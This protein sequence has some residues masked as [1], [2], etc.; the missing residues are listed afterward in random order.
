M[1]PKQKSAHIISKICHN[2]LI[3]IINPHT[4][5]FLEEKCLLNSNRLSYGFRTRVFNLQC[6][7]LQSESSHVGVVRSG[8]EKRHV[9]S[10][11]LGPTK[12]FRSPLLCMSILEYKNLCLVVGICLTIG[13]HHCWSKPHL[14]MDED[15]STICI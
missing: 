13:A 12:C 9:G 6:C 3:I 10:A 7:L 2:T 14:F 8:P 15:I 4:L 1:H 11:R 5:Y